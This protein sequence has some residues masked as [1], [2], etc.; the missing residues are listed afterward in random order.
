MTETL[1]PPEA[2]L[3]I[4]IPLRLI[5][6][7]LPPGVPRLAP[8]VLGLHGYAMDADSL[9]PVLDR[10]VPEEFLLVAI[11][12]PHSTTVP[13]SETA[14]AQPKLAFHWGVSPRPEDNRTAHRNAVTA[15]LAWIRENGGDPSRVSLVGFS[16]PCSFNY[17]LA[18]DPPGGVPF[19]ALVAICGGVPGKWTE[20]EPKATE[21]SRAAAVLH[22]STKEDPYYPLEKAASFPPRLACRFGHVEHRIHEGPHRIPTAATPEIREFLLE[23]G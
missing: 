2:T 4:Q 12:G 8:V 22:V 14:G 13:G 16:Q 18:L 7:P 20:E 17:R 15:A 6:R 23:R 19:R 21:A 3:S 9:L 1:G 11:Q 10:M 5:H